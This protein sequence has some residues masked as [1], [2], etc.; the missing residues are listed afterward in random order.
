MDIVISKI[1]DSDKDDVLRIYS[2]GIETNLATFETKCPTWESW[3]E[4][5]MNT[6]R[7]VA[8]VDGIV[9]GF[10]ALMRVSQRE[11]YAGVVEISVYVDENKKHMGIGFALLN[12][13]IEI[14]DNNGLWTLQGTILEENEASIQ[15]HEKCGFRKVG[16][17]FMIG[18]DKFGLWRNTVLMER[19]S[20]KIGF[21]G[22]DGSCCHMKN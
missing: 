9:V 10:A 11:A 17:R 1:M 22:C 21:E 20:K 3:K 8:K 5:H 16:Y 14:A 18:K 2:Q 7:I 6:G 4:T 13:L 15:L 12:K 19:R